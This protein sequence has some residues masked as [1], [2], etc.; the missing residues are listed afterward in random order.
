[1]QS[2]Y[3]EVPL[4]SIIMPAYN[5]EK[6]IKQAIISVQNQTV[7]NWELLVIDDCST[8]S[9]IEIVEKIRSKDSRI[10]LFKNKENLGSAKTR[11][12]GFEFARGKYTALLDS[13]DY[14]YPSKLEKQIQQLEKEAADL[15]YCSYAIVDKNRKKCCKDF[16][17]P[18]TANVQTILI[19][20]VVSCSTA[21]MKT[22]I[23][24]EHHFEEKFYHEDYVYWLELLQS[25]V[26]AVGLPE[27]LAEY[28]QSDNSKASNKISC[29]WHRWEIYRGYLKLSFLRSMFYFVC[30][31]MKGLEKYS[32]NNESINN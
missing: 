29:A 6:F 18:N 26:K 10:K 14:W 4:V 15:V 13:D 20:S 17:V 19:K 16:I 2:K 32:R 28:R 27:V 30:Y 5:A 21:L 22:E 11:N 31:C 1:M 8:D 3:K 12:Y 24:K 9:T 23:V 7:K 25:G